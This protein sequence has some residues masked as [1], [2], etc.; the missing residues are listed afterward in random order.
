MHQSVCE[1]IFIKGK[2]WFFKN[3]IPFLTAI[4]IGIVSFGFCFSNKLETMDDLACLFAQGSTV[5]SGRWGLAAI[6]AFVPTASIPWLNGLT[7]LFLISVAIS[8]ILDMFHIRSDVLKVILSAVL[9]TFPTHTCTFGY[10]FTTVQYAAALLLAVISA[11]KLSETESLYGH[12]L[13]GIL[14]II[15]LSIYQ[16][17]IAVTASLIIVYCFGMSF[18]PEN[19]GKRIV[20]KGICSA[21]LIIAAMGVYYFLTAFIKR[22]T[23]TAFN[24][25]ADSSLNGL[26][27]VFWGIRVAYT[28]FLGY[29]YKG[30]YDLIPNTF[31]QICH[32]IAVTA[33]AFLFFAHFRK[34]INRT[35]GRFAAALL[36]LLLLPLGVNCIRVISSLFHNL[37]LFSFTAVYLLMAVIIE[38]T[39]TSIAWKESFLCKDLISAGMVLIVVANIFFANRVYVKMYMQLE[40]AEHFYTSVLS[41]LMDEPDFSE[42]STV[43]FVGS[44]DIL[45]DIPIVNT[46]NQAG[47][48]EG[49]VG[50]YSQA[51]FIKCFTGV[52]LNV[53]GWD[54]TDLLLEN[55]QVKEMPSY[56]YYGSIQK[57]DGMFVV[58]LG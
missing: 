31:S 8:M 13:P 46:D 36:C 53:A 40:Q 9:V 52:E 2:T 45:Y 43:C 6:E 34:K 4:I 12:I 30:Y 23:G 19:S 56:P 20:K 57:V 14:L 16:P 48:R 25:Y 39:Q 1:T 22:I 10:M 50:T 3:R 44:N 29:F 26:S 55:Q 49:I 15:S 11:R 28:S 17:Y 21:A 41:K 58:K 32:V 33:S 5:S 38:R 54:I 27:D 24:T 47:I 51:E 35:N 7:S 42:E 37:M 18:C